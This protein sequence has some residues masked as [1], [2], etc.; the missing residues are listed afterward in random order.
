MLEIAVVGD[1]VKLVIRV[2]KLNEYPTVA[3]LGLILG[4]VRASGG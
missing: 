4:E 2:E 1:Y 3:N